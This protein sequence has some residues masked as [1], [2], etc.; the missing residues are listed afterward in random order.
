[1]V[2]K[3]YGVA[4]AKTAAQAFNS[5]SS[6]INRQTPINLMNATPLLFVCVPNNNQPKPKMG[7]PIKTSANNAEYV[8]PHANKIEHGVNTA[9]MIVSTTPI[10]MA[11]FLDILG[12]SDKPM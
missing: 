2:F 10:V 9:E 4:A 8:F 11:I 12:M 6:H 3:R 5:I 7:A 1:M